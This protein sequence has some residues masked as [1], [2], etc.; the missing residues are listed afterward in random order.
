MDHHISSR[1][2]KPIQSYTE[3]L[4]NFPRPDTVSELQR[5]LGTLNYYRDYI[6]QLAERA[7]PLYL[8]TQKGAAWKWRPGQEGAFS[9]LRRALVT[10]PVCL[11]FPNWGH[12]FYVEAD[13]SSQGV[14]AILSQLDQCTNKLRPISY[15]SS[16]LNSTQRN[17]GAT[18]LEAWA[19]VSAARKWLVYLKAASR[20]VFLSDHHPLQWLRAQKDPWHTY[21]RWILELE[22]LPYEIKYRPGRDN[23]AADYLSRNRHLLYDDV[24]NQEQTF[25]E[26]LYVIHLPSQLRARISQGQSEDPVIRE[27]KRQDR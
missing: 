17:Y 13:G 1:G 10:E 23:T 8:L 24:I 9:S 14:A 18:Q 5:F 16:S 7:V 3:K 26:H 6:P 4:K 27:A 22:E 2:K 11:A 21:A 20:V 15:F 19:L 12:E 25:E